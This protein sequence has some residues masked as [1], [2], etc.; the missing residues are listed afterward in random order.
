MKAI[1]EEINFLTLNRA[2]LNFQHGF[3][4][5]SRCRKTLK[6]WETCFYTNWNDISLGQNYCQ[7]NCKIGTPY[8]PHSGTVST[9]DLSRQDQSML[10]II[11]TVNVK[12]DNLQ[13]EKHNVLIIYENKFSKI[14]FIL[15]K[16]VKIALK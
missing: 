2:R 9:Y 12:F 5:G 14:I 7:K 15:Q 10:H 1:F 4:K 8:C 11:Y 3:P 16:M 6:F 13:A